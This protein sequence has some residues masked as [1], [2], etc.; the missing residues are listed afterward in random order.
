MADCI[1]PGE[2]TIFHPAAF[3]AMDGS[4]NNNTRLDWSDLV[5][6]RISPI[7][8]R[9]GKSHIERRRVSSQALFNTCE[10]LFCNSSTKS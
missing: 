5:H 1:G 4:S 10:Y 9:D 7:S 6:P 3:D 8:S 2:I